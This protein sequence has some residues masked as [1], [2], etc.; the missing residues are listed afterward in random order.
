MLWLLLAQQKPIILTLMTII[1]PGDE[2][3]ITNPH[4][5]NYLG[6]IMMVG[7]KVVF[8]PIYEENG[9]K[10]MPEYL[11]KAITPKTKAIFLNS[12]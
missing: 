11:E 12:P 9:F 4:Y 1:N 2:V 3:I 7:G 10:I 8:V 6:Q 5:P